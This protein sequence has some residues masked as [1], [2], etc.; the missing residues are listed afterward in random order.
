MQRKVEL[1]LEAVPRNLFFL[2][3]QKYTEYIEVT[4]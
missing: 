1:S 3:E 4:K 2:R